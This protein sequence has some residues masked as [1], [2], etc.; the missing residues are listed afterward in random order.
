MC[1]A[2]RR[3]VRVRRVRGVFGDREIGRARQVALG[4]KHFPEV[5]VKRASKTE[6]GQQL[7]VKRQQPVHIRHT[8][9]N[10]PDHSQDSWTCSP[11]DSSTFP[12]V[13]RLAQE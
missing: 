9:V 6:F 7:F 13:G 10:V 5:S 1:H 4:S 2:P 12:M 3:H 11:T 8:Q